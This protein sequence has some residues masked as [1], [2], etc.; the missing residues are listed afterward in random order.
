MKAS[1][2]SFLQP[3]GLN[4]ERQPPDPCP[5]CYY[6]PYS[7]TAIELFATPSP[8]AHDPRA[9]GIVLVL[10]PALLKQALG[11]ETSAG[12]H[13]TSTC[14]CK[15]LSWS[16]YGELETLSSFWERRLD[17]SPGIFYSFRSQYRYLGGTDHAIHGGPLGWKQNEVVAECGRLHCVLRVW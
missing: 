9:T 7:A 2:T 10:E 5:P 12:L 3:S 16:I 6:G 13:V 1:P 17:S 14:T 4:S 15:P 11:G 8:Q